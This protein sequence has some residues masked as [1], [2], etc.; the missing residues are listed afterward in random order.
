MSSELIRTQRMFV[1]GSNKIGHEDFN[2]NMVV[3]LLGCGRTLDKYNLHTSRIPFLSSFPSHHIFGEVF[4]VSQDHLD[5][6]DYFFQVN[7]EEPMFIREEVPIMY[8]SFARNNREVVGECWCYIGNVI[9]A[10]DGLRILDEE[11]VEFHQP[12]N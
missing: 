1:Y 10:F 8:K 4:E 11:C 9:V 7:H 2:E 5:Y 6:W 12:M 3:R